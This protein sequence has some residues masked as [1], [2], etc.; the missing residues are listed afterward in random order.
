MRS[1]PLPSEKHADPFPKPSCR[2]ASRGQS[3]DSLQ[4]CPRCCADQTSPGYNLDIGQHAS[5]SLTHS[6]PRS[7]GFSPLP[8][9]TRPV[10]RGGTDGRK[11][12]HTHTHT[13]VSR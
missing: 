3:P 2:G 5:R 13:R 10:R 1:K 6:L 11:H 8:C 7:P 4:P 12:T 9:S